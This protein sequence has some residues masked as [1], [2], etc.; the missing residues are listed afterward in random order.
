MGRGCGWVGEGC[1]VRSDTGWRKVVVGNR[2]HLGARRE[3]GASAQ[4]HNGDNVIHEGGS[5]HRRG[6]ARQPS[7]RHMCRCPAVLSPAVPRP[8]LAEE[9]DE[10]Y[11]ESGQ[12]VGGRGQRIPAAGRL[13]GVEV[14]SK[15]VTQRPGVVGLPP[16]RHDGT[17]GCVR[18]LRAARP[19]D[20]N[21]RERAVECLVHVL[22]HRTGVAP[23][24]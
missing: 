19:D 4:A 3:G 8:P 12:R 22:C 23:V 7:R 6:A 20:G 5:P 17:E 10:P 16:H 11:P 24:C 1:E 15:D 14:C 9:A 18:A 21:R 2:L 13:H